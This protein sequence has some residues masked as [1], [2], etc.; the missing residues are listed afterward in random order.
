M[1]K[2][3]KPIVLPFV[4]ICSG[5]GCSHTGANNRAAVEML[6]GE[7]G[8]MTVSY[9]QTNGAVQITAT[10][11]GKVLLSD[12][13]RTSARQLLSVTALKGFTYTRTNTLGGV[14]NSS[15]AASEAD[16]DGEAIESA[17]G[18]IG[19]AISNTIQP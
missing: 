5:I 7:S 17:G 9:M 11:V 3:F 13:A 19:N 18:A 4:L 15:I 6:P 2:L 10:N 8:V 14:V 16:P 12:R 1:K